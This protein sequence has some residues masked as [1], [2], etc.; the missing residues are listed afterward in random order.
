MQIHD[1]AG[2]STIFAYNNLDGM[3]GGLPDIGIGNNLGAGGNP[4]WTFAHN[5]GS[6]RVR[7]LTVLVK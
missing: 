3:V 5:A 4:D 6:Y 1:A 2:K 7:K